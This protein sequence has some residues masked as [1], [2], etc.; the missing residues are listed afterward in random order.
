MTEVIFLTS[1]Q[2]QQTERVRSVSARLKQRLP[3]VDIKVLD[4]AER[5][6]LLTKHKLKFGPA[7]LINGLLEYVGVPRLSM[8]VARV[9]QVG[10]GR[11]NPRTAGEKP[12][13]PAAK[14]AAPAAPP[15]SA[16]PP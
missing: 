14:P 4:A 9:L 16:G 5:P 3:Q 1:N 7:V 12:G 2:G 15:P 11:P 8:L 13:A 10:E 6:D